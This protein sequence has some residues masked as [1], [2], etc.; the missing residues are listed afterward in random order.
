[1]MYQFPPYSR[2]SRNVDEET[3]RKLSSVNKDFI[4]KYKDNP[5]KDF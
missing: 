2:Q 1:M 3:C 5:L 4:I